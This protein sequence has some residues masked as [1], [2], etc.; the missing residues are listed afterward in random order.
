MVL[1][2]AA[3]LFLVLGVMRGEQEIVF[4]KAVNICMECIGLG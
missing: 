1:L 2:A 4:R 3:A